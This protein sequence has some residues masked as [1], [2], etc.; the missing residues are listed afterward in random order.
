MRG[1]VHFQLPTQ[2]KDQDE[3]AGDICSYSLKIGHVVSGSNQQNTLHSLASKRV[4]LD[5]LQNPKGIKGTFASVKE[6]QC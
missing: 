2:V 5:P 4:I 6:V 1:S 3:L